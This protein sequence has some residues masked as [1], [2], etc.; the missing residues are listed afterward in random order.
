MSNPTPERCDNGCAREARK[1]V[2]GAYVCLSC[3]NEGETREWDHVRTLR[4]SDE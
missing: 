4:C 1:W 2:D 3:A